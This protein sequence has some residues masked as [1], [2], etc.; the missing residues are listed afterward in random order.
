VDSLRVDNNGILFSGCSLGIINK[1]KYS[2][3]KL[4]LDQK[5]LNMGEFDKYSP[6]I[7]SLDFSNDNYLIC[8]NSSSIYEIARNAKTKPNIVMQSHYIDEL[9]GESW[10][11]TSNRFVTG[12]D[13]KII[14]IY[15]ASNFEM[16]YSYKMKERVRGLDWE[17]SKGEV[18]VVGDGAGK[19]YL[20]DS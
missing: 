10:S 1:W 3:G 12:G 2:G 15:N 5:V 13:D 16:L 8:T 11:P 18:I 4:V 20:F 17:K 9:W 7:L 14:R 19:I 6:G